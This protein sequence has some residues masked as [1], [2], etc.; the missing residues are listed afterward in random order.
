MQSENNAT[1]L[2]NFYSA[3]SARDGA[4]MSACYH[5]EATFKDPVFDLQGAEVG[6]MWRMLCSRSSDLRVEATNLSANNDIGSADWQAWYSFSASGRAV[7]NQV[8]SRFRF[9]EGRIIEQ[10][11]TFSFMAWSRQALGPVGMLLGWTPLLKGKVRA[12]ARTALDHYIAKEGI[13]S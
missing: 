2:Q 12:N 6:A 11:D 3:F 9:A 5:A 1:L 4:G 10:V 13:R 8:H 7:H